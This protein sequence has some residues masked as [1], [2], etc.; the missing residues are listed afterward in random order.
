ML[1]R[2]LKEPDVMRAYGLTAGQ[3]LWRRSIIED[4]LDG[5]LFEWNKEY[6]S[7]LD[8]CF[9][10]AGGG[11]FQ[12]VRYVETP[13]W[14]RESAFLHVMK[15]HPQPHLHYLVGGDVSAG[16]GKDSSV[17]EVFC[18]ETEEQVAE[19][20]NS[21]IEPDAFADVLADLGYRFNEG[22]LGVE[23]NNHGILTL[24]ELGS[25]DLARSKVKYPTNKVYRT[26]AA[27]RSSGDQV[28]R[29]IDLGV[30]TSSRSKPIIIGTLRIKLR[31]SATI[32]S[33]ILKNELSTYIEWPD[34]TMGAAENCHDDTVIAAGMAFFVRDRG[35]LNLL[36]QPI[37]KSEL[38]AKKDPFALDSI[39]AEMTND[40]AITGVNEVFPAMYTM[41]PF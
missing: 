34:G 28:K 12:S 9:Q 40:R 15:G 10:T 26:P 39:I 25:Y 31:D 2:S 30:R 3:I 23:S 24:K 41:E 14:Q 13:D 27:K 11:I 35:A 22:Y 37:T 36:E 32:H 16:V 1:F 19:Y 8:D 5:D 6:P 4:E 21:R 20:I 7:C 18:L 17:A 29:L 38:Y 33:S